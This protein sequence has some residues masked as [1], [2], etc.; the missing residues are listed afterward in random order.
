MTGLIQLSHLRTHVKRF[1]GSFLSLL[2]FLFSSIAFAQNAP[3]NLVTTS[4][5]GTAISLSWTAPDGETNVRGY[6]VYRCPDNDTTPESCPLTAD[7]WIAWVTQGTGDPHPAPTTYTDSSVSSGTAYTYAV[8]ASVGTSYTQTAWTNQVTATAETSLT[9]GSITQTGATLTLSDN[10]AAWWYQGNQTGATC[11]SVSAGTTTADLTGLTAGTS[12]T[13]KAYSAS[14]CASADELASETFSTLAAVTLEA[15]A[16]TQTTATLTLSGHSAAWWY[17]GDQTGATCTS[18]GAGTATAS[19][20]G[21]TAGTSYTYKAYSASGCASADELAS[22]TFATLLPTPTALKVTGTTASTVSL[23]WT[24]P[25]GQTN[26]RGYNVYRCVSPCTLTVADHWLAWVTQG[27]G[28]PHP[29][30]TQY[31]DSSVSPGTSYVYGVAASVNDYTVT[32]LSN[33]VTATTPVLPGQ[34]T[35]LRVTSTSGSAISLRW[36]APTSGGMIDGYSVHRCVG[37]DCTPA[38]EPHARVPL[39]TGTSYTDNSVTSGTTYRYAVATTNSGT[40]SVWSNWVTATAEAPPPP[41]T[42]PKPVGLTVTSASTEA[43]SLRWRLSTG[44]DEGANY[45]Y[46]VFRCTVPE[47]KKTCEPFDDLWLAALGN[48]NIYTDTEVSPGETYRYQVGVYQS[49]S[50]GETLSRGIT[51][52]AQISDEVPAPTALTVT[53]TTSTLVRLRWTA[54]VDDGKGP[55]QSIDIYRCNVDRSPD[56]SEFLHL[57]SRNPVLTEMRDNDV[58]PDT[59]YRYVVASYRSAE[60]P[61]PWSNQVT[62]TT[63]RGRNASPTGLTVTATYRN[64]ISLSWTAPAEG[65]LGYNIYRCIVPS[66]ESTCNP[67]WHVWVANPGD[68]P[69]APTSY[70]D[71]G[72]D[73]GGITRN[74]TYL[75][76]VQASY[77]PNYRN[78]DWS[79]AVTATARGATLPEPMPTNLTVTAVS[80][81]AISLSWTAPVGVSVRGYD[82]W[83]CVEGDTPCTPVYLAWVTNGD[84]DPPPAPTEYTDTEVT[85]GTN[86]RYVVFASIGN[87]YTKTDWSNEVTVTA[88]GEP[89]SDPEPGTGEVPAAPTDL[90]AVPGDGQITLTWTPPASTVTGWELL[91]RT[92]TGTGSWMS[93]TPSGATT[94]SYTVTGLTNGVQY[95]F[96]VRAVNG[97]IKGEPAGIRGPTTVPSVNAGVFE[98]SFES[99]SQWFRRDVIPALSGNTTWHSVAWK[100]ERIQQHILVNGVPQGSRVTLA[101]SDF[102]TATN[103]SIPAGAVSFRYPRFVTGHTEARSCSRDYQTENTTA[104][105]SDALFSEPVQT[106]PASWPELVWM[107]VDIPPDTPAG[108]YSGT[109][110]VRSVSAAA[111]DSTELHLS[112]QVAPWAMPGAE[113]RQFHLD[114]WQFPV[115]V[116]DRYNDANPGDR[117]EI[118]SEE[119]YALL[120]PT[121]RYLAGLGQRTVTTYIKEGALGAPSMIQW[122][123][124]RDGAWEYDYSVFDTYVARLAAWGLD[125]QI[126]AFSPVGWNEG[127]IPYWDEANQRKETFSADVGSPDWNDRWEHFLTDFRAHL[128]EQEWFDKTVL[129][130]DE[131][132]EDDVQ[133]VIDLVGGIDE[134]WKIGLA[135]IGYGRD[136]P[137][138]DVLSRLY[139]SSGSM[140]RVGT[141]Y[142]DSGLLTD[143]TYRYAVDACND[144][145]SAASLPVTVMTGGTVNQQSPGSD[146]MTESD[147]APQNRTV[148]DVPTDLAAFAASPAAIQL[149]WKGNATDGYNVYRCIGSETCTP[150]AWLGWTYADTSAEHPNRISTFYTSCAQPRP[151]SFVA[152]DA[153]P[154][155]VAALPWHA[156]QRRQDGYLR[157]AFDNWRSSDPLD[158][159]EG[160]FTAGDFS[161]VYRSSNDRSMTVVP[162]IRSEMLR[163][164]IE[165]FEKVQVLR[166]SLSVCGEDELAGRWLDRLERTV[167]AFSGSPLMAGRAGDL[168]GEAHDRLGEISLQMTPDICQ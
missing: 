144:D 75:Y 115:S 120:E 85:P 66:G 57:T 92:E 151:N 89:T 84:G 43:V 56:C 122:T 165:D 48:T 121:Y 111:I 12:Y 114:L 132:S 117:I 15:S 60:E 21:L 52:T 25:A 54:P 153:D 118:W 45:S 20:T 87:D 72:G 82:V 130:L 100:G 24:A 17:Q 116:L 64:A 71:T 137:G 30:P 94:I 105:L 166:N 98:A 47:G 35:N 102:T 133:A 145:C 16:I 126:S 150:E 99:G 140:V 142:V 112:I 22:E 13:Y 27:A 32:G 147:Q 81:A 164:G 146:E 138:E 74:L 67:V 70:T 90:T 95:T 23:S 31:T 154:S 160:A 128:V 91:V 38:S 49:Y 63:K 36:D 40:G 79:E 29:A 5:S 19:L 9:A 141:T 55:I 157:W 161:L 51:V 4:I 156:L 119:H 163:D 1:T 53:E 3:T 108:E 136:G 148:P 134:N 78:G 162:S 62:T 76:V 167:D 143:E 73:T 93:I 77:P 26:I 44:S 39:S 41:P 107:A 129:Y 124:K 80:E 46:D 97:A 14:G 109:V 96:L 50:G 65:I 168:I 2:L 10:S 123:L 113:D 158:L 139:D 69:P 106:L 101:V 88:E 127:E 7:R 131:S 135:Y 104:Y 34:P 37:T 83:R 59:T 61:S 28:D 152:A 33:T 149:N 159:R 86:Y 103:D 42:P 18:V 68:A 58:E 6:N 125:E 8:G 110:S 155:D 11:T